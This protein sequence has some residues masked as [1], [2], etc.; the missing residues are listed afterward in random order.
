M[1]STVHL[2][3]FWYPVYSSSMPYIQ[4]QHSIYSTALYEMLWHPTYSKKIQHILLYTW[5][6]ADT[7][8]TAA[9]FNVFY[10]ITRLFWYPAVWRHLMMCWD[11]FRLPH[12]VLRRKSGDDVSRRC[13]KTMSQ[14]VSRCLTMMS[15][16]VL[17]RC[18]KTMSS[19]VVL[20]RLAMMS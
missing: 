15:W 6:Y 10:C 19:D 7:L 17:R 1:H 14:H 2:W 8:N 20:R 9:A 5:E 13:L 3:I 4:Q 12:D 16:D 11:I 18:L